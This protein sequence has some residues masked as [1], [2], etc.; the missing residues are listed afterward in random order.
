MDVARSVRVTGRVQGVFFRA[1]AKDE[2][3]TIG[4]AGWIRNDEDGSVV[5]HF[6]G[7]EAAIAEMIDL[8]REGPPDATVENVEVEETDSEGLD[9]FEVRH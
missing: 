3:E 4:L 7:G 9:R 1:W 8:M 2:A 6:E 5:A